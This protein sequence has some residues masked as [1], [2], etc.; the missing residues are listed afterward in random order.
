MPTRWRTRNR[1]PPH[2]RDHH[3]NHRRPYV[4][5]PQQLLHRADVMTVLEQMR[6]EAVPK[7]VRTRRL[8]HARR[9]H[10][11]G[12][13]LLDLG[14]VRVK[15]SRRPVPRIATHPA[16][17]EHEL[18]FPV[19][20]RARILPVERLRHRRRSLA[21]RDV[22]L[23]LAA[24]L[25]EMRPQAVHDDPWQRHH[26][27][28]PPLALP[29]RDLPPLEIEVLDPKGETLLDSQPRPVHQHRRQPHGA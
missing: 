14:L 22:S 9:T 15:P 20:G 25:L 28:L 18:P 24:H 1:S 2:N 23:V 3:I 17:R 29:H 8:R 4:R 13:G 5:V 7:G 16:R 11:L 19:G 27:V 21:T 6:R 10:G 12:H 26:A